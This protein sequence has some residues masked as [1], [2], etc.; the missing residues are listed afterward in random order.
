MSTPE[1]RYRN[2]VV[3][4]KVVDWIESIIRDAKLTPSE[5]RECAMLAAIHYEMRA[6][7]H[8]RY[9]FGDVETYIQTLPDDVKSALETLQSFRTANPHGERHDIDS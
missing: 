1:D 4:S 8:G 7:S 5:V 3:Y 9:V 6:I 2:D